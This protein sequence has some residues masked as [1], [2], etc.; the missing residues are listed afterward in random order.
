MSARSQQVDGYLRRINT[1]KLSRIELR[2]DSIESLW[3]NGFEL[4]G[5]DAPLILSD[6]QSF[7]D[8]R[9]RVGDMSTLI[10]TNDAPCPV[11]LTLQLCFCYFT[12]LNAVAQRE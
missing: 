3:M 7:E 6:L 12:A 5:I 10:A 9:Q 1:W 11:G 8:G 4:R 2:N